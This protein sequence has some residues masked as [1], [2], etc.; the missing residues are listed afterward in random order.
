MPI[1]TIHTIA[2]CDAALQKAH[3]ELQY[4]QNRINYLFRMKERFIQEQEREKE[5]VNLLEP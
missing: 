4:W 3:Q 2:E 5:R 1:T